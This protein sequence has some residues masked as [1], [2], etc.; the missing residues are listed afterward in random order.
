MGR[1]FG[2]AEVGGSSELRRKEKCRDS[3]HGNLGAFWRGFFRRQEVLGEHVGIFVSR[4]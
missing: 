4:T 3:S 1:V 2:Q